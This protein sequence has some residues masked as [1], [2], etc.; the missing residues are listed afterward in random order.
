MSEQQFLKT[1]VKNADSYLKFFSAFIFKG[2]T[3]LFIKQGR[4]KRWKRWAKLSRLT[5]DTH[6]KIYVRK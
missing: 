6:V 5:H 3:I 1:L 2:S 4:I